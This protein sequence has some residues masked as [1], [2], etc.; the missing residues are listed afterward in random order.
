LHLAT[1]IVPIWQATE[2]DLAH[3]GIP[4]P[5]WAFAW[6]GGQAVARYILDN[7][8]IVADKR[9]LDFA[10]GCGL[11]AIAAAKSGAASVTACDIDPF[12]ATAIDLNAAKSG[13]ASVTACDIDPFAATA[14]DLNATLNATTVTAT[15]DDLIGPNGPWDVILAGDI[16]YEQPLSDRVTRWLRDLSRDGRT[17][18]LGDP[19]RT[20]LPKDG[21]DWV[22]RY[23]VKTTR[24][25]EDTDVRNAVVWKFSTDYQRLKD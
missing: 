4:P 6:A 24:E 16:C 23:A 13:A 1:E 2:E 5:Y 22:V 17:V 15:Q 9:V 21:L 12:A 3:L 25:L 8:E 11:V 18:L 14:I 19:G 7:P 10:S 20:Y